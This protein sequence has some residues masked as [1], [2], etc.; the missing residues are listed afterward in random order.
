MFV[1]SVPVRQAGIKNFKSVTLDAFNLMQVLSG[2][3]ECSGY[4]STKKIAKLRFA[5]GLRCWCTKKSS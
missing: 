2:W 5:E 4:K 3:M 1:E